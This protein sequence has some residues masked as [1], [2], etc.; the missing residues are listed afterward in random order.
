M[1][2]PLV[3]LLVLST[4]LTACGSIRESRVNPFN[5][6]GA[7]REARTV[8][9]PAQT[10]PL[11]PQRTRSALRRPEPV[12]QGQALDQVTTLEVERVSDG[13]IV[14][15]EGIAQRADAYDITLVPVPT[16]RTGELHFALQAQ[17]PE[18]TNRTI[19]LPRPVVVATHLTEQELVGVRTI[20]VSAARN[21]RE[22][23]R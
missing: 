23:R 4:T 7:S 19:R 11:I 10:N 13:A 3:A 1:R 6:F 14:R 12:F 17:F 21:A 22:T 18:L 15:V 5:W 2:R 20:R 16:E 9:A 8:E